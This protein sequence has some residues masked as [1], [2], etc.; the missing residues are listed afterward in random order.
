[1]ANIS[2]TK[3]KLDSL[4]QEYKENKSQLNGAKSKEAAK[5]LVD[6]TQCK[7]VVIS[8]I[9]EQLARFSADVVRLYFDSIT[10]SG[11]IP[12]DLLDDVLKEFRMTDSD[13][14]KSQYYVQKFVFAISAIMK[15]YKDKAMSSAQLPIFIAFIARYALKSEKNKGLFQQ[16]INNT[17][18]GI[19]LLDYSRLNRDSTAN[20]W[21]ATNNIY[22]DLSKAKY[23]SLIT[24]WGKKYKFIIDD[25][26]NKPSVQNDKTDKS[27]GN[28][29]VSDTPAKSEISSDK[30][31][32]SKKDSSS[33]DAAELVDNSAANTETKNIIPSE[34]KDSETSQ[35]TEVLVKKLYHSI[36]KDLVNEREAIVKAVSEQTSSYGKTLASIQGEISKSRD[37]A[38]DNAKLKTK[39]EEDERA[40][41]KLK[42]EN[43]EL[44]GRIAILESKN[45]EIDSKLN[46]AY[47]L[48]TR[49]ASL[50]A[51]KIRTELKKSFVSLYEDWLEY[52]FSDV[53]EA[54]YE[55]LQAI[56]KKV[57]RSLERNGIDFKGNN[58]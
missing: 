27:E 19:Y 29:K 51:E 3:E 6:M 18:G 36:K 39:V 23:E 28:C 14:N 55:S 15:N 31:N 44:K 1:M 48:N 17:M 58:E 56:I 35:S 16:L 5:L 40:L 37:L 7:D 10:R 20:V 12:M 13:K 42:S 34:I 54:N 52:E 26:L 8:D 9:A 57:F 4:Y 24:E 30:P 2:E 43:E 11:N 45:A 25:S 41:R 22:P 49:E 47:S 32:D 21:N 50:E 33:A 38:A 46:E 53:S